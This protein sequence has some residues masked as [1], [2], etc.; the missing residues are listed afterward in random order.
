MAVTLLGIGTFLEKA[1]VPSRRGVL[2]HTIREEQSASI[3]ASYETLDAGKGEV[4]S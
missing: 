4:Q 1:I 2:K 3:K